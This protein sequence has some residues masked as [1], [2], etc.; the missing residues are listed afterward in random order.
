M[1][2]RTRRDRRGIFL[3]AIVTGEAAVVLILG[4]L[5]QFDPLWTPVQVWLTAAFGLGGASLVSRQPSNRIG[6]ILWLIGALFGLASDASNYV[7]AGATV[8]MALPGSVA[9]AWFANWSLSLMLALAM[10]FLPFLFPDGRPPSARWGRLMP[11]FV[12]V[13]VLV[14]LGDMLRPG[15]IRIGP[16]HVLNPTGISGPID[17]TLTALGNIVP[18]VFVPLV[19][20]SGVFRF[21]HGTSVERQ[22]IK[23]FTAAAAL[24]GA[25]LILATTLVALLG[26]VLG[27]W[28]L[29]PTLASLGLVP[30]A[31]GIA[32]TR[33]R[34]YEIDRIVSRTIAWAA[35]TMVLMLVFS[36][37]V[38]GLDDLLAGVT[39]GQTLAVAASTL[40]AVA[41][42]QPLRRRVQDAVDRRFDRARYD[43]QRIVDR[44]AEGLRGQVDLAEISDGVLAAVAGTVR[45][46]AEAIWLRE[47]GR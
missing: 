11:L 20:A 39:Q 30:I 23:W 12:V 43:A 36:G 29:I 21:R 16:A 14:P 1:S 13:T 4:V 27:Q 17:D 26:S 41:L 15:E 31:V 32:V 5:G 45:P 34:L 46:Q 33:Y 42:F 24:T 25:W 8:G 47:R 10:G 6:W 18:V 3:A 38:I 22:Q 37:A 35:V 44:L 28:T 9:A 2:V 7:I 19:I 40:A